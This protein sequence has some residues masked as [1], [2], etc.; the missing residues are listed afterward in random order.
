MSS[1]QALMDQLEE[2]FQIFD[3]KGDN[4]IGVDR[5]GD[6]LR[7]MGLNPTEGEIRRCSETL[8][9]DQRITFDIFM[10]IYH[11]IAKSKD[12]YTFE[13]LVDGLRNFDTDG[14]GTM[15]VTE[16]RY[17]LT[18]LGEKMTEEEVEKLIET[19]I[20]DEQGRINYETFVKSVMNG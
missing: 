15:A 17:L 18:A 8:E 12:R 9:K 4:C 16:L 3:T 11:Q 13:E 20:V 14:S 2:I 6:A 5:I 7:A 19:S 1:D 10:P